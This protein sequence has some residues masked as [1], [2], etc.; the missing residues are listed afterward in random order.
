MKIKVGKVYVN[1]SGP[2][3]DLHIQVTEIS[4]CSSY[5]MYG[6]PMAVYGINVND[7]HYYDAQ[8]TVINNGGARGKWRYDYFKQWFKPI[9]SPS[10]IWKELNEISS[11]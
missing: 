11:D 4:P 5:G 2:Y 3:P 8:Q 7:P 10:D 9:V 1:R 6:D